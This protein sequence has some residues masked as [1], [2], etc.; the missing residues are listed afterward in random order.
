MFA[1]I[2]LTRVS[3]GQAERLWNWDVYYIKEEEGICENLVIT[4]LM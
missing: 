2:N 3:Q 4:T 1:H